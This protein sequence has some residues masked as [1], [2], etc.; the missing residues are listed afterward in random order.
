MKKYKGK[1]GTTRSNYKFYDLINEACKLN[2]QRKLKKKLEV[3]Y[4]KKKIPSLKFFLFFIKVL[5]TGKIFK[6]HEFIKLKYR[7]CSVGRHSHAL[8]ERSNYYHNQFLFF[9][10]RIKLFFFAGSVVDTAYDLSKNIDA[11]FVDHGVYL[12]GLY[13]E[14]FYRKKIMIYSTFHPKGL[15]C[16]IYKKN[17]KNFVFEDLIKIKKSENN[18]ITKRNKPK[19]IKNLKKKFDNDHIFDFLDPIKFKLISKK[20][21][22][23]KYTYVIYVQVFS[24]A[25][26]AFGYS[27]FENAKKWLIH[28]INFLLKKNQKIIIKPHPIFYQKN[29]IDYYFFKKIINKYKLNKNV[30]TIDKPY[31][32]LEFLKNLNNKKH[33]IVALHSDAILECCLLK[34]KCISSIKT[35]WDKKFKITN[36]FSN[37]AEYE[38]ILS[39]TFEK[40]DYSNHKDLLRLAYDT[41]LNPFGRFGKKNYKLIIK[42]NL[43][44]NGTYNPGY[45]KNIRK[46]IKKKSS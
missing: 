8:V 37:V 10:L 42:K 2:A 16:T 27:G 4:I 12:N 14:V 17:I 1:F 29:N 35:F 3:F 22:F 44:L 39:K 43:G 34:F 28:T 5:Y 18:I 41:Y 25:Q 20:N 40:L 24:D 46:L 26:L 19:L 9:Y 33:I 31:S 30:L 11:A 21:N 7:N 45:E 6:S 13:T 32:N 38:K 15:F 36:S 23:N